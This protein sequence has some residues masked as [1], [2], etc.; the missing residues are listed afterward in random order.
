MEAGDIFLGW[1]L[2]V[3][4]KKIRTKQK[5]NP[6]SEGVEGGGGF[7]P[8]WCFYKHQITGRDQ[9]PPSYQNALYTNKKLNISK[10][11]LTPAP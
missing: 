8:A 4:I 11:F 1:S 9:C 2:S 7:P 10:V 3:F 5:L 6:D